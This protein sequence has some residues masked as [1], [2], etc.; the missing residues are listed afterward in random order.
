MRATRSLTNLIAPFAYNF[1]DPLV[2][3][4]TI[5]RAYEY[6]VE[7]DGQWE[8][9]ESPMLSPWHLEAIGLA[10]AAE[11]GKQF[12]RAHPLCGTILPGGQRAQ[13]NRAPA[14]VDDQ[15]TMA[16]R[17]PF[18]REMTMDDPD[19]DEMFEE[20][21]TGQ[22][23]K[24]RVIQEMEQHFRA[25]DWRN[26]LKLAIVNGLSIGVCANQ[27]AGKS[28]MVKRFMRYI[29]A[30]RR[31]VT[32]ED[33]SPEF[34]DAGP[35]NKAAFLYGGVGLKRVMPAVLRMRADEVIFQEVRGEEVYYLAQA[36]QRGARIM[37]TWHA[38]FGREFAALASMYRMS[39][40]GRTIGVT[41][42]DAMLK[43]LIDIIV[44][45]YRDARAKKFR[46]AR[47]WFRG[48]EQEI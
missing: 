8:R 7:R 14:T 30:W 46:V 29:P 36:A 47:I 33:D 32:V 22:S 18:H 20:V 44:W 6:W 17:N 5:N 26:L 21:N 25:R 4:V 27:G 43:R 40:F 3:D 9:H 31:V 10:A 48:M 19:L 37:T 39:E 12:S 45:Q 1:N 16:F 35:P 28:E 24:E 13:I 38:E 34:G 11:T 41:D 15:I 2:T 23:A 42:L